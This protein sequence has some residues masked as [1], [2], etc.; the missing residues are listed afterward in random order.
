M[1]AATKEAVVWASLVYL[2]GKRSQRDL[3]ADGTETKVAIEVV[4]LVN[5]RS[6]FSSSLA[7]RLAVGSPSTSASSSGP[8]TAELI[9]AL[10]HELADP[11]DTVKAMLKIQSQFEATGALPKVKPESVAPVEAWLKRLRSRSTTTKRG[12]V[13]FA[14]E[15]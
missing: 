9:A 2:A 6:K 14:V 10:F 13:T 1:D 3:L 8:D 4:A 11:A 7:G 5:G 12:S 15:P